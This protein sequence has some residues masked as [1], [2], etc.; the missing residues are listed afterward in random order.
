MTA[1]ATHTAGGRRAVVRRR[2]RLLFASAVG[3]AVCALIA[4]FV[5]PS[6]HRV[7]VVRVVG[8]PAGLPRPTIAS[9]DGAPAAPLAPDPQ[10]VG[11]SVGA[12]ASGSQSSVAAGAAK[13][14][15]SSLLAT[16]AQASFARLQQSFG[17]HVE[18]AILPLGGDGQ[19]E[20]LGGD[21]AAH[22]WS[23]MKVP[24]LV[25]LL[26]A[27]GARGLTSSEQLWA[28]AAI[29]ESDNESI[30][31]LFGDLERLHGG[32]LGASRFVQQLFR[33]SGDTQ[34]TVSTAAPP[35]G[36]VTTFGQTEWSPG[37]AVKFFRELGRGCLLAPTQT[38]YVLSLMQSIEPSESWGLGSAGFDSVAFKGGWGPEVSGGYLVRQSGIVDVG[39][40]RAAAVAIVALPSGGSSSFAAGT[41]VLD[42]T[43]AWLRQTLRL[44]SGVQGGCAGE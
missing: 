14:P 15:A 31:E 35:A 44:R 11:A 13:T 34:T 5:V 4:L 25:A 20:T 33:L 21:V 7:T 6:S 43:S 10:S 29:T 36:A 9:A 39:T 26:R 40:S 2:A 38:G 8:K 22:G 19:V 32:L 16:G 3:L 17:D 41:E 18:L 1:R 30:L 42:R 27:R 12:A 28:R 23:T 24:V 37:E